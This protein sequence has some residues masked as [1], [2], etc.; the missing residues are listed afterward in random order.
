[1]IFKGH[2]ESPILISVCLQKLFVN[3]DFMT[4]NLKLKIQK[5]SPK[6][7]VLSDFNTQKK[8]LMRFQELTLKLCC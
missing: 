1:M 3:G 8:P 6:G 5:I 7:F 4:N 2:M